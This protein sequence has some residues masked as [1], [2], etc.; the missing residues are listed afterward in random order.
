ML[1]K[2]K[3]PAL[4]TQSPLLKLPAELRNVIYRYS[5]IKQGD[6]RIQLRDLRPSALL[7]TCRQIR[8]EA[9]SIYFSENN[10]VLTVDIP[11]MA[12]DPNRTAPRVHR[13]FIPSWYVSL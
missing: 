11:P 5:L 12:Y 2:D 6:A 3:T 10:F 9:S 8:Y 1:T 4:Q 13:I 7:Y